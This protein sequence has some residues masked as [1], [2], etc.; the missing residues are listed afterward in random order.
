MTDGT[1]EARQ[2]EY[3]EAGITTTAMPGRRASC[4][5][6]YIPEARLTRRVYYRIL[7]FPLVMGF[8]SCTTLAV[9]NRANGQHTFPPPKGKDQKP[10][11][12]NPAFY[13]LLPLSIPVDVATLP[14]Q[15]IYLLNHDMAP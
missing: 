2:K 7:L 12:P 14:F 13:A 10:I 3:P 9:S 11:D 4:H 1:T 15:M 8:T 6:K 5:S